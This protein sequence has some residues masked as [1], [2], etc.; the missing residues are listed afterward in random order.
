MLKINLLKLAGQKVSRRQGCV[1][2]L[3]VHRFDRRDRHRGAAAAASVTSKGQGPSDQGP[4]STIHDPRSTSGA[5]QTAHALTIWADD[6]KVLWCNQIFLFSVPGSFDLRSALFYP[7]CHTS[8][9]KVF[10][11]VVCSFG[12]TKSQH[13][14]RGPH[15]HLPQHE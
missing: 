14:C 11:R 5:T 3:I 10:D 4:R 1:I 6:K 7:S 8:P 2:L 15:H 13:V 9:L 12:F